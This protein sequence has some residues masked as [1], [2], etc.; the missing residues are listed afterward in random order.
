MSTELT[1]A[2]IADLRAVVGARN[3]DQRDGAALTGDTMGCEP[4]PPL[5]PELPAFPVEALPSTL[6]EW[7]RATAHATQTPADLAAWGAL[8]VLASTAMGVATV[9]C[10]SWNEELAL[11]AVIAMPSGDRK[12]AVLRAA[13]APLREL[14]ASWQASAA[15]AVA[16]AAHRRDV[17]ERRAR[18]LTERAAKA[19]ADDRH[20][21]ERHALNARGELDALPEPVAPR[22]LADDA[23]PEALAGLLARH[24]RIAILAAESAILD[25]APGRYSDGR[26]NLHL[27]CNAYAGERTS[28]D[29]R[30]R[31]PEQIPRP[32]VTL[33]LTIQ[34]IYLARL[35]G[36]E[37][38]R[39]QGFVARCV[40][41]QPA[42]LLGRRSVDAPPVP[43]HVERRWE[44]LV[45]R[46]ADLA[47]ADKADTTPLRGGPGACSVG[48]VSTSGGF[49]VTLGLEARLLLNEL[50][51]AIEPRLAPAGN[52]RPIAAWVNRHAGRIARLAALLHLAEHAPATPV[53]AQTMGA[54]LSIG[55]YTL[56]HAQA[57]L[58]GHDEQVG[59]AIRWLAVHARPT[60]TVRELHRGPLHGR[61]PAAAADQLARR[62]SDHGYLR[63]SDSGPSRAAGG[64]PASPTYHVHPDLL[65]R[66]SR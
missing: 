6:G 27:L 31:A 52:L 11:Y 2:Q 13:T 33:A 54:A 34:P 4:W 53:S 7:V 60:V 47:T 50:R 35:V 19:S 65:V 20:E 24:G 16:A 62:L 28:I 57:A 38:A 61:G 46:F 64:R 17:L 49:T 32:L 14:E 21:A 55:A 15:P 12:S 40:L 41:A 37:L 44:A 26:A 8:A 59:G 39:E 56:A 43:E 63:S 1:A 30:G 3:A 29:R 48:S 42:S 23:T 9:D 58:T 18:H 10:G 22:L 66:E 51:A 25:N 5:T 36:D 45:R